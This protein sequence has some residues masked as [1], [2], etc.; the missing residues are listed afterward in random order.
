MSGSGRAAS[1]SRTIN[2]ND[3]VTFSL[4]ER[5]AKIWNQAH[6]AFREPVVAHQL[7]TTHL[8]VLCNT[9]GSEMAMGFDAVV[10]DN[11]LTFV[12]DSV[13]SVAPTPSPA[14]SS[15]SPSRSPAKTR[16]QGVTFS[17]APTGVLL[18]WS[19]ITDA[20]PPPLTLVLVAGRTKDGKTV[21][22]E[23]AYRQPP[24]GTWIVADGSSFT[25]LFDAP[26]HYCL[27]P[28]LPRVLNPRPLSVLLRDLHSLLERE[29]ETTLADELAPW[30]DG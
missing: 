13:A 9:L 30:L 26:T 12:E 7:L 2:L 20:T 14:L 29:C 22:V 19:P 4:T 11:R 18:S 27:L 3:R 23:T 17:E 24:G 8:W 21:V 10:V 25:G 6:D 15:A 16:W 28:A 5:G 1:E